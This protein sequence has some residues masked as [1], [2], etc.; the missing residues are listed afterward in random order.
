MPA[1]S[2]PIS[3]VPPLADCT[4][5]W[6][7]CQPNIAR[8]RRHRSER[9]HTTPETVVLRVR[10][11]TF[12][13]SC[14]MTSARRGASRRSARDFSMPADAAHRDKVLRAVRG[15]AA[16]KITAPAADRPAPPTPA[17]HAAAAPPSPA[18]R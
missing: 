4:V 7:G 12:R 18:A 6:L 15:T 17:S 9:L 1:C 8:M 14:W 10:A 13:T 2:T 11:V 5:L 3:S 16:A